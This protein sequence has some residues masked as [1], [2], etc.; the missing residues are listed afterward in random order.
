MPTQRISLFPLSGALLFPGMQLPLHI[1]E[2]RYRALISDAMARDRR[3]GMIQ[4]RGEQSKSVNP[5]LYGIG[6]LGHIGEFEALEDGRYNIILTGVARFRV[7]REL[8]V[9]TPFR[10][11]EAEVES[12]AVHDDDVLASAERAALEQESQR[13]AKAQGYVV[14][15]DAVSRLDDASLVNGIAQIAP[16]DAASKQVLLEAAS[17]RE[18][19]D[20]T[21]QLMQFFGRTDGG[22][23]ATLQ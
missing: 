19:A 4:P 15:W 18:R 7:V 2:P 23:Q 12:L 9:T 11:V 20:R 10:Q 22:G 16:F 1:F 5:D 21:I 17:L 6:C 13:F 14:D 3:I 8:T